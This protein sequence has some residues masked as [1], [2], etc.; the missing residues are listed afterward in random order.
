MFARVTANLFRMRKTQSF[1]VMPCSDGE[2]MVQSDRQI[3][4]FDFRT[5]KGVW[6]P[7]GSTFLHL[8]PL[9]GGEA[10]E[11]PADFVQACLEACPALDSETKLA[12]G[13]VT[14]MNTIQVI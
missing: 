1:I 6:G 9:M 13:A 7:K 14:V 8:N 11:Y 12:G 2:I 4:K 10:V 5:R 3:G